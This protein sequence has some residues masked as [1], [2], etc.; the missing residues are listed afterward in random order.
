M[1]EKVFRTVMADDNQPRPV[2]Y[3]VG[4]RGE[5]NPDWAKGL[6]DEIAALATRYGGTL[7]LNVGEPFGSPETD[8][9]PQYN[10]E[11]VKY[12]DATTGGES[13]SRVPVV[14]RSGF[15]RFVGRPHNR[16][17]KYT[18]ERAWNNGVRRPLEP[19]KQGEAAVGYAFTDFKRLVTELVNG[20]ANITNVGPACVELLSDFVHACE[21]IDQPS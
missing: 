2:P 19:F 13:T 12:L 18:A 21:T 7:V 5:I 16:R 17:Y 4:F 14:N 11:Y 9:E 8:A 10:P 20:D 1:V 15:N 3:E 6:I